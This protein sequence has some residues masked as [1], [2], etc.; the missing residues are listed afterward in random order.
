[1]HAEEV[2]RLVDRFGPEIYR[3]C[4]RLTGG[5]QQAEDLYQQTFLKC[6]ELTLTLDEQSNPRALLFSLAGGIFK[7]EQRK[8]GRRLAIARPVEL[9]GDNAPEPPAPDD[10]AQTAQ[11][12]AQSAALLAAVNRLPPKLRIPITLAYGF[13]WNLEEIARMEKAPVGT[14]KSRLH[15]ARQLLKK[16]MEAQGYGT[17]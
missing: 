14:I 8:A 1:M 17:F 15:K 9:D 16:E 7:N 12:R 11:N 2:A 13:D 10:P 4:R 6:L 5:A 3:Y